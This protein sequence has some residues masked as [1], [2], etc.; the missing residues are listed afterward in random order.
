LKFSLG[1]KQ[2]IEFKTD[3]KGLEE[4]APVKPSSFF[5]P[6]WFKGM[7]DS[8]EI[9]GLH[10]K[11]KPN[12]FG[13]K[14]DT[15]KKHT[16]GTVKRCPAI[17]DLITEG[18]IIPM[19]SDFL[20]QRDMETFE[21]DNKNFKYGIE[22]HSKEQIKGWDL[23]K[24]DFPEG[25]K[26]INPWRI[27]TPKG[28][29]VMFITP[30]YQFEKRFTV[31]P[32]I[33]ETDSYHHVNFPSVWHTTKDAIIERGTP[34]IQVIPFKRDDWDYETSQMDKKDLL[35]DEREKTELGTKFKNSYRSIVRRL[36]GGFNK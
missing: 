20:V 4:I 35:N 26:F 23:K 13:K 32:G 14:G 1:G 33:V 15:A 24:T 3:V 25:V 21:W 34:F 10:E 36:N 7:S 31:L 12:Y 11:G 28:Y 6:K 29:S 27:H 9:D 30:T 8:V 17:V 22:F 16:S 18:F 5:L 2:F 19:W